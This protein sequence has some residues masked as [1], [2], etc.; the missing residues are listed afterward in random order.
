MTEAKLLSLLQN[1][2]TKVK[3]FTYL[4][5]S[6]KERL[7]YH[8]RSIVHNPTFTDDIVQNTFIKVYHNLEQFKGKSAL[9]TWLYRIATN[10]ALNFLKKEA[11]HK[12]LSIDEIRQSTLEQLKA[13]SHFDLSNAEKKLEQ[14]LS[15]LPHR[16]ALVFSMY[17]DQN[18]KLKAIAEILDTSLGNVKAL[19]HHAQKKI[20]EILMAT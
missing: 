3:G 18:L 20:K 17:Y 1:P 11:K 2:E 13:D 8:I 19:H 6:Y 10:E 7:Y 14:A 4:F 5:D 16:Q 9:Y 15:L 12:N